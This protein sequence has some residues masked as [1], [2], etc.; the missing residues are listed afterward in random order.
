MIYGKRKSEDERGFSVV[1]RQPH[2]NE[3]TQLSDR[4]KQ[5]ISHMINSIDLYYNIF[6]RKQEM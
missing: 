4:H 6:K 2:L 3:N 1:H 5:L